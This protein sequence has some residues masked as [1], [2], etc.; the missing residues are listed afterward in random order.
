MSDFQPAEPNP[1]A[2]PQSRVALGGLSMT[3]VAAACCLAATILLY[4]AAP[5]NGDFWWSE[6]PRNALNGAFVLDFIR[7]H[8]LSDPKGWAYHYYDQYPALTIFFYP[9]LFYLL[10]AGAYALLGVSHAV[11]QG[12][13][14]LFVL[15]LGLGGFAL[16][17][18]FM[19]PL[20]AIGAALA[21]IG[22]PEIALWGRAVMLDVPAL[23]FVVW[24]LWT[25][26]TFAQ[27][28]RSPY[29]YLLAALV[30]GA[31]YTK[32]NAA[33]ILAVI[34]IVLLR[35]FGW[36]L[37]RNRH[38]WI[39]AAL[40]AI[41]LIPIAVME[42]YFGAVNL[43]SMQGQ[44]AA[45]SL[46]PATK[47][48]SWLFYIE[49]LPQEIGWV[50]AILAAATLVL[51]IVAP[52]WRRTALTRLWVPLLWLAVGYIVF[53]LVSLKEPRHGITFMFPLLILACWGIERLFGRVGPAAAALFGAGV[54]TGTLLMFPA[55]R[56]TG[57]R[58][59]ADFIAANAPKDGLV[60]FSGVRDGSFIFD[61]RAHEERR[62]LAVW[63]ADKLLLDVSIMRERGVKEL[64]LG[65][66]AI[67]RRLADE[68]V[69]YVVA[70]DGFWSDLGVM[71][72]FEAV[73][74]GPE[75]EAVKQ[76]PVQGNVDDGERMLT[77]YRVVAPAARHSGAMLNMPSLAKSLAPK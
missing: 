2:L 5:L 25:A 3:A 22:A 1:L 30:L 36:P 65:A 67:R 40:F 68:G 49:A 29:L 74:H 70:Q 58:E 9:P 62:D 53:G 75:F 21:L 14:S 52:A 20:A 35:A 43:A 77:I 12:T 27:T 47:L 7:Q 19:T 64:G 13:E 8:P 33:Y 24:S 10:E 71:Q 16:A 46:H 44:E 18:K 38:L 41:G 28:K 54:V 69:S 45:A 37:F 57:Y 17:R 55:A 50:P 4:F 60:M 51:V 72:R 59:A 23:A 26:L 6:A 34:G 76:I 56:V 63:R 32:I 48:A 66:D 73:L 42:V 15:M 31:I 39:A 11:A 61:I